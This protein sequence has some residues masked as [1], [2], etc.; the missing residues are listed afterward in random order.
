MVRYESADR[1]GSL[2]VG[3]SRAMRMIADGSVSVI[4]TSPPY[5]VRGRG[6]Q[7]AWR[8]ARDLAAGFGREWCRIL[9]S[10]GDLWLVIGD[11]HDG[12]EWVGVDGLVTDWFR[13]T[14]WS[15]QLKGFWAEH[16]SRDRWDNRV[17]YLLRFKKAGRRSLPPKATLS[18]R[19]PLPS[20]PPGSLWDATPPP[21]IRAL[22]GLSSAGTVLDPFFGSGTVGLVAARMGRPWI[23]V[24]RDPGQARV[25]AQRLGLRRIVSRAS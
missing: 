10:N 11:R 20:T 14:G 5:W 9:A 1:R 17:N 18:W 16:P 4:L 6:R 24:E 25:A 21:V 15:L 22:L 7:S 2:R 13:R 12:R 23:G 19:F 8:Y 3:D